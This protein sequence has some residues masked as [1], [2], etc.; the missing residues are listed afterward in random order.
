MSRLAATTAIKVDLR[1]IEELRFPGEM[2]HS[3]RRMKGPARRTL[4]R[5]THFDL[6]ATTI[7]GRNGSEGR[8]SVSEDDRAPQ[9]MQAMC[10]SRSSS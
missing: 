9:I 3:M 2:S 10:H 8:L 4:G 6:A 5:Q 1:N 7:G